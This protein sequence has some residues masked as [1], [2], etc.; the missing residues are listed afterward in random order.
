MYYASYHRSF[1]TTALDDSECIDCICVS[2]IGLK[3]STS[4]T[5]GGSFDCLGGAE[6]LGSPTLTVYAVSSQL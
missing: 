1:K 2:V 3:L 5:L 4:I 6:T